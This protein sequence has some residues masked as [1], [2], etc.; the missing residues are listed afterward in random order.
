MT[1]VTQAGQLVVFFQGNFGLALMP[2]AFDVVTRVLRTAVG[3]AVDGFIHMYVDDMIGVGSTAAWSDDRELAAAT[4]RDLGENAEE[5][6]KRESS[7]DG[8]TV[9]GRV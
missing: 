7:A 6:A 2:F 4:F 3:S 5:P 9:A 8:G 1:A